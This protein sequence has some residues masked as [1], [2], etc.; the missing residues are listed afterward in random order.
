MIALKQI[1]SRL[2]VARVLQ[3]ATH[4]NAN[5]QLVEN[6]VGVQGELWVVDKRCG[7]DSSRVASTLFHAQAQLVRA[8]VAATSSS[9]IAIDDGRASSLDI[10]IH[11]FIPIVENPIALAIHLATHAT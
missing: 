2:F 3:Y 8:L 11:T 1:L 9:H 4:F 7:H 10:A 5:I 6:I